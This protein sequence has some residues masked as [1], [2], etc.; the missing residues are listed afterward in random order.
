MNWV[1]SN[2]RQMMSESTIV[3]QVPTSKIMEAKL[4]LCIGS[5]PLFKYLL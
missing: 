2:L 5:D 3:S 1:Y 4:Q